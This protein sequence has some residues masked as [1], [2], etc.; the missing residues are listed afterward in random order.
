MSNQVMS[1]D[2][3]I[4]FIKQGGEFGQLVVKL[5]TRAIDAETLSESLQTTVH[6]QEAQILSLQRRLANAEAQR[7]DAI[8]DVGLMS[9]ATVK[10]GA[11]LRETSA[12]RVA[13]PNRREPR[14][15]L[16][17]A[18]QMPARDLRV[19]RE[20]AIANAAREAAG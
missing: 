19:V 20:T 7:D 16:T 5:T 8:R 3:Q 1:D 9:D 10:I 6:L 13:T 14:Q 2:E 12:Q 4:D 17:G 15:E 18:P 11:I